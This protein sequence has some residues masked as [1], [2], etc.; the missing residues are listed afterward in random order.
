MKAIITGIRYDT[1]KA[2]EIGGY[3]NGLS[4]SDFSHW[5]ATLYTTPR[6]GRYFLSGSGGPMSRYSETI[7]Q[8]EWSGGSRIDPLTKEQAFEW[9]QECL[10]PDTVERHFSDMVEDA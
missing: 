5:E 4:Y 8:N 2:T 10:D 1:E 7:G 3:S 6:S 9:A